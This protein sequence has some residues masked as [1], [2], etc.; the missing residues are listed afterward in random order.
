M[1][2]YKH[3]S[4][5]ILNA[6]FTLNTKILKIVLS[7]ILNIVVYVCDIKMTKTT[8]HLLLTLTKKFTFINHKQNTIEQTKK[9]DWPHSDPSG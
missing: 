9:I 7:T 3:L 4:K 2:C 6:N 8:D 1:G 5:L